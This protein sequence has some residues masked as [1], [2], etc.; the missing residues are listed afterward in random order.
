[1]IS[2]HQHSVVFESYLWHNFYNF[3]HVCILV[4]HKSCIWIHCQR[5]TN[6]R[7]SPWLMISLCNSSDF[8]RRWDHSLRTTAKILLDQFVLKSS[9]SQTRIPDNIFVYMS[10]NITR[11]Y[12][13]KILRKWI[14]LDKIFLPYKYRFC[15][16]CHVKSFCQDLIAMWR[17]RDDCNIVL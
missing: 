1:M 13:Y 7:P 16:C 17:C 4:F 2:T 8:A 11:C 10:H 3:I 9:S 5:I 12:I 15:H 14:V 6:E